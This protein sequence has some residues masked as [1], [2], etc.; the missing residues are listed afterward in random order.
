MPHFP[1]TMEYSEKY[2]DEIYEYRHVL[3]P[4]SV[5]K[6]LEKGQILS[7]P[8]W[9]ELGVQQSVGWDHYDYHRPEPHILLFR[10]KI[11]RI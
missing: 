11:K 9:R 3:L 1:E 8:E 6:Q 2:Y 7:E 10:R 4:K 5:Y